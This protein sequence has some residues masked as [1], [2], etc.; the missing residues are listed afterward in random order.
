MAKAPKSA[1]PVVLLVLLI[2][3]GA[4][5]YV[6]LDPAGARRFLKLADKPTAQTAGAAAAAKPAAGEPAPVDRRTMGA[7]TA[8]GARPPRRQDAAKAQEEVAQIPITRKGRFIGMSNAERGADPPPPEFY[9]FAIRRREFVDAQTLR[10]EFAIRNSS[11]QHWRTAYVVLRPSGT[12]TGA[13]FQ[14]DDWK[15]DETV[16]ID[17]TFPRA[18]L[19]ERLSE[20][21]VVS[22]S[23]DRRV[24]ALAELVSQDRRR[25]IEYAMAAGARPNAT[26]RRQGDRLNA[27]GLLA[28]LGE[29]QSPFTGIDVTPVRA[30]DARTRTIEARIPAD[31]RIPA[32]PALV[33][34]ETSEE[35]RE[36]AAALADFHRTA[37]STDEALEAFAALLRGK[38]RAVF[39]DETVRQ[40]HQDL[41]RQIKDF[42]K[43][44]ARLARLT[45]LSRDA[46]VQKADTVLRD[47]SGRIISMIEAL[48]AEIRLVEPN[49][50]VQE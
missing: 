33:L 8:P 34:R 2:L 39:D 31:R 24:S 48:D 1:M 5:G 10:V 50:R 11:G 14:I 26:R 32:T 37:R 41:R 36:A 7:S 28:L 16:G 35:R 6:L 9:P 4:A 30:V 20:L 21:R 12:D 38:T 42:N 23:G 15:M 46:E 45:R 3:G 25:Y 29:L 43:E 22:V 44:G 27:P 47:Y 40:A 49:F 19:N 17:Y 18:E 13:L